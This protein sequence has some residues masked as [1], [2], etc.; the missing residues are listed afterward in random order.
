LSIG[1]AMFRRQ[2]GRA[3][4]DDVSLLMEMAD[5]ALYTA[6]RKGGNRIVFSGEEI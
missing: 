2:E 4:G 3:W 1:L 5:K 6:K